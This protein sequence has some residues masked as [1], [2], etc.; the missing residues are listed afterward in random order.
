MSIKDLQEKI[1]NLEKA[2]SLVDFIEFGKEFM[3]VIKNEQITTIVSPSDPKYVFYQFNSNYGYAISRPL[4][5]EL[6]T[7]S[8]TKLTELVSLFERS[9]EII[10]K[11]R[12]NSPTCI[13]KEGI[14]PFALDSTIYTLQQ[15]VGVVGDTLSNSNQSRK[16]I[17]RLF[18]MLNPSKSL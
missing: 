17:G 8:L 7:L 3:R 5:T 11:S 13:K 12:E 2:W 16:L 14:D 15:S 18:E 6:F 1:Q 10:D 9:L 4:N